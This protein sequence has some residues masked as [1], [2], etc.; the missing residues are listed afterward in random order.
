MKSYLGL[1]LLRIFFSLKGSHFSGYPSVV[2]GT[3]L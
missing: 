1:Y 3:S 2:G